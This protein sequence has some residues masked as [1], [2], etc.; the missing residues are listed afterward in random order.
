M[1]HTSALRRAQPCKDDE[2]RQ[3]ERHR[4]HHT[5]PRK[6]TGQP[7]RGVGAVAVAPRP[8]TCRGNPRRLRVLTCRALIDAPG[9][10]RRTPRLWLSAVL[11]LGKG[12]ASAPQSRWVPA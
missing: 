10:R 8:S 7:V 6:A 9:G 3:Q 2:R 12:A 4:E 11:A 1:L 5:G